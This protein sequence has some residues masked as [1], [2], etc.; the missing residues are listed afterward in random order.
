MARQLC[1]CG[2]HAA[3]SQL[4]VFLA[5]IESPC[6][7]V[8]PHIAGKLLLGK[9]LRGFGQGYVNGFGGKVGDVI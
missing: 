6:Q 2:H 1:M 4:R 8:I 7:L 5:T 3:S 9:K